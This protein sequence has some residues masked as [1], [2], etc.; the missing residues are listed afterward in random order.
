MTY[1]QIFFEGG[2]YLNPPLHSTPYT[3][4]KQNKTPIF[5]IVEILR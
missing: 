5:F 2:E 4:Y 3:Y 1:F